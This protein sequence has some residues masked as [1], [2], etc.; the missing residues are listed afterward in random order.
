[1]CSSDLDGYPS[2][3]NRVT[4]SATSYP[5]VVGGGGTKGGPSTVDGTPGVNSSGFGI[6][7]AGGGGGGSESPTRNGEIGRASCRERV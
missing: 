7:A 2:S 4:V 6:T 1:M 3:P 5:I